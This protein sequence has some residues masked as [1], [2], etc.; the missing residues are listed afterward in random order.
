MGHSFCMALIGTDESVPFS[1]QCPFKSVPFKNCALSKQCGGMSFP[2]NESPILVEGA[3]VISCLIDLGQSRSRLKN[4]CGCSGHRLRRSV[5]LLVRA[6]GKPVHKVVW[7]PGTGELHE[8]IAHHGAGGCELVLVALNVLAVNQ[9]R[10]VERHFAVFSKA[11]AYFFVEG[12]EEAVHLEADGAR[13]G[14]ALAGAG[15]IL[16]QI[17][18]I[19]AANALNRQMALDFRAVCRC[20]RGTGAD[21][22][23]WI[24]G[25]IRRR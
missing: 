7:R 6:A 4:R 12:H 22:S 9:V 25:G 8:A 3:F 17:A 24:C 5:R 15:C 2:S 19:L 10:N 11:A 13:A 16:A 14:L 1:K 23:G 18:Q 21:W 20:C